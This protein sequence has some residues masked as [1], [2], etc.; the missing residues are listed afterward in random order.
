MSSTEKEEKNEEK[1]KGVRL[2]LVGAFY[3]CLHYFYMIS[4]FLIIAF[5]C[6]ISYLLV[7]MAILTM[8]AVAVASA[9]DCPLNLLEQKYLSSSCLSVRTWIIQMVLPLKS[10]CRHEF[11]K[12]CEYLVNVWTFTA[13]K[14][15]FIMLFRSVR[16]FQFENANQLYSAAMH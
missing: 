15:L 10:E 7:V 4:M 13:M 11:E 14:C 2:C 6:N 16:V 12:T 9:N 1:K 3:C 5:S 8:N